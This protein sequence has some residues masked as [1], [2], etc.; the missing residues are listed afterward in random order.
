MRCAEP[1]SRVTRRV[2]CGE[3]GYRRHVE[4]VG[5]CGRKDLNMESK[6][7]STPRF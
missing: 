3:G 7:T 5:G 1:G 6:V 4:V 2:E